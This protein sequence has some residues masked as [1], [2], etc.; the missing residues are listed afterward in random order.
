MPAHATPGLT[1]EIARP[2]EP[3]ASLRSDIAGFI[4]PTKRGPVDA[5]V[6]V[7]EWR[8]FERLFGGLHV[9]S[10]TSYAVRSYFENGGAI[11]Y[12]ARVAAPPIAVARTKWPAHPGDPALPA[13]ALA[14]A[15]GGRGSAA[16]LSGAQ[17]SVSL[18]VE[19][20]SPGDWANG[21]EISID[22]RREGA[23]GRA[24]VDVTTRVA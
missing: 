10:T 6:R 14:P 21:A 12:V 5:V 4:G 2:P 18:N 23:L 3:E 15:G 7:E 11:A 20:S 22:Y 8:E 17:A 13:H 1:F 9:S 19:A 16:F 24:E